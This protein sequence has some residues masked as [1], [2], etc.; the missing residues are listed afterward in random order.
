MVWGSGT[1]EVSDDT[2]TLVEHRPK[3][4]ARG[5]AVDQEPAVEVR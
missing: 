3:A 2:I 1:T 4:C 5:V